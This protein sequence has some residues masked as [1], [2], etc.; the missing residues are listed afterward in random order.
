MRRDVALHCDILRNMPQHSIPKD[1]HGA[2]RPRHEGR[3]LDAVIDGLVEDGYQQLTVEGVAVRAGVHKATLYRWWTGK[4]ALV[5]EALAQRMDTGPVPDTGT[6]RGD[7]IA[8]LRVTVANYTGTQAGVAMPALIGDL[9][10]TSHGL[11]AFREAFLTERRAGCAQLVRRGM[12]RGD[13]PVDT[14]VD[15]FLDA[16]AGAVFYRQLV[17]GVPITAD[18]PERIADLLL[19]SA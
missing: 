1:E 10:V 13:L 5:A 2:R 11:Q 9:A 17:S 16:L 3:I 12:A 19:G 8:W 4:P 6:T 14:D 15:L 7:L 18:L